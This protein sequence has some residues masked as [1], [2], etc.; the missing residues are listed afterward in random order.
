MEDF[1]DKELGLVVIKRNSRAKRVIVRRKHDAVEMTVP[2]QLAKKEIKKH[3]EKL[4][5]QI[6]ALSVREVIKIDEQSNIETFTFKV[7]IVRQTSFDDKIGMDLSN[8]VLKLDVHPS[9]DISSLH[10]QL[11]LKDLIIYALRAEAHRVLPSKVLYFAK[12]FGFKVNEIKI[13]NSKHRWGS[14]S[15]KK[16]INLSLFLMMLPEHLID[17]VILHELAHTIELNHSPKFWELLDK[18]CNGKAKELDREST[19][20]DSDYLYSLKQ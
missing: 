16:N 11:I 2:K 9:L 17:Y 20:W 4:K 8:G 15:N 14:C 12:K 6:L 3:F 18:L 10:I 7:E 13:N 1:F 19:Y 5:P